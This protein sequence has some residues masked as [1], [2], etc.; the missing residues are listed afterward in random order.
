M[1]TQ[2]ARTIPERHTTVDSARL[3]LI[4]N[5]FAREPDEATRRLRC[6]PQHPVAR[7][8]TPEYYLQKLDFL[9]RNPA[10]LAYE[11][12]ELHRLHEELRLT[13][14]ADENAVKQ[15]VCQLILNSEPEQRT[16]LYQRF[17]RGA[18]EPLDRVE[19]WWQSRRLVYTGYERRG[20]V[21]SEA[22][23]QKYYFLSPDGEEVSQRLIA[24]VSHA[25]W[26][27]ERIDLIHR[28]FGDLTPSQLKQLQYS[29]QT[30]RDA[31]LEEMI[32]P[33]PIEDITTIYE[34]VFGERLDLSTN[35]SM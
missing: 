16:D 6:Y 18:Y 27:N 17:L 34:D 24:S 14:A 25:Q 33:L 19:A 13:A 22:R 32:P 5:R 15:A 2:R 8:L 9:V 31:Q 30:Y 11:L 23:P 4:L 20:Q 1:F 7:F 26:Y 12:V 10:Y 29:H 3:L 35:M 28:F 21:G